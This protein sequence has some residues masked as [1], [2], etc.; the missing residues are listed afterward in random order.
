MW[1]SFFHAAVFVRFCREKY[2]EQVPGFDKKFE[3][4]F[5]YFVALTKK[6]GDVS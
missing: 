5:L 1:D 3:N 4:S 6:E 2:F